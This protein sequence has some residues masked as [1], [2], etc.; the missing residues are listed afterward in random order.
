VSLPEGVVGAVLGVNGWGDNE[1]GGVLRP[2]LILWLSGS[3]AI[4][5]R[6][7][8]DDPI[9]RSR[10][11]TDGAVVLVGGETACDVNPVEQPLARRNLGE[12]RR[13]VPVCVDP[14]GRAIVEEQMIE[15]E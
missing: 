9:H 4:V 7:I 14:E 6:R 11:I 12:S 3:P 10:A 2:V 5:Y 8:P 15:Y 1:R 13:R